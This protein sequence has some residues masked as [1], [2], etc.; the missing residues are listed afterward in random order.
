M[1]PE[2]G[3]GTFNGAAAQASKYGFAGC[4]LPVGHA[5]PCDSGPVDDEQ[6]EAA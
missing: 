5:P 4:I 1:I 3:K 2:C 6:P